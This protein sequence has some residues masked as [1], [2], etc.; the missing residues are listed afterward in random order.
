VKLVAN[1]QLQDGLLLAVP[2]GVVEDRQVLE[3]LEVVELVG[4][5]LIPIVVLVDLQL[6]QSGRELPHIP[7]PLR[8]VIAP[9]QVA[10]R[11]QP[12]RQLLKADHRVQFGHLIPER[13]VVV[14]PPVGLD[15]DSAGL[16]LSHVL[17]ADVF[18]AVYADGGQRGQAA[19]LLWADE[20]L[21]VRAQRQLFG[22]FG[23]GVLERGESVVDW[24]GAVLDVAERVILVIL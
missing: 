15:D 22:A 13:A 4:H 2:E 10:Q 1:G 16:Q 6:P 20:L 3:V 11:L 8:L 12:A 24:R 19:G 9:G 14:L 18:G 5:L 21:D 23:D 17:V 7:N